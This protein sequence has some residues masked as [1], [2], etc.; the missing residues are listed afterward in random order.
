MAREIPN[1]LDPDGVKE[2]FNII[3]NN[4]VPK[5]QNGIEPNYYLAYIAENGQLSFEKKIKFI[6]KILTIIVANIKY[7]CYYCIIVTLLN[8]YKHGLR[9]WLWC[10]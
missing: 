7:Y 6:Y 9:F 5:V 10:S 1:Y 3:E 2:I 8:I 4:Y